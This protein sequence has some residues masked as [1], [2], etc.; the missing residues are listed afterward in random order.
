MAADN[1]ATSKTYVPEHLKGCFKLGDEYLE[2]I[3]VRSLY[4]SRHS[5]IYT[6]A[7]YG[8]MIL[9]GCRGQRSWITKN[10]TCCESGYVVLLSTESRSV[11]KYQF[12]R[13]ESNLHDAV[14]E[15][16]FGEKMHNTV[17]GEGFTLENEQLKFNSFAFNCN[18]LF[19]DEKKESVYI[20]QNYIKLVVESWMKTAFLPLR[21]RVFQ[22][23]ELDS[24][25]TKQKQEKPAER[26]VSYLYL[27]FKQNGC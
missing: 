16:A 26:F 4:I 18:K 1:F 22:V 17:V 14:Y 25:M 2:D 5:D 3:N 21:K 12:E 20:I 27:R 9:Y 8:G 15:C 7:K 24:M 10:G 11:K 19:S 13:K 23:W 6:G